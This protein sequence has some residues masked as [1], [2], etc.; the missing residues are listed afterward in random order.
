MSKDDDS[1]KTPKQKAQARTKKVQRIMEAERMHEA[2]RDEI[3]NEQKQ[4]R[5]GE[6]KPLMGGVSAPVDEELGAGLREKTHSMREKI[7]SRR[8]KAKGMWRGR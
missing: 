3:K 4:Q 8:A 7:R 5:T 1:K 2:K 6:G